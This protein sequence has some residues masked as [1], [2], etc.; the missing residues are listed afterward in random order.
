MTA[1]ARRGMAAV[2]KMRVRRQ[3]SEAFFQE[4]G[5]D[6]AKVDNWCAEAETGA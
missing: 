5:F 3:G 6:W 1:A 4:M 2:K